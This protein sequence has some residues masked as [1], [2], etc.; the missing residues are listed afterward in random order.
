M[1]TRYQPNH[2]TAGQRTIAGDYASYLQLSRANAFYS[3]QREGWIAVNSDQERKARE[4]GA[5]T[6]SQVLDHV[7]FSVD[8]LVVIADQLIRYPRKQFEGRSEPYCTKQDLQRVIDRHPRK[9]GVRKAREALDLARIGA[10]SPP[11][12]RLRLA[13]LYAGLPEPE[14]NVPIVDEDGV[15]RSQPDLSYPEYRISIE[16]D[17]DVHNAPD[18]V[19]RDIS[20]AEQIRAL[21]WTEVR[22]SNRHMALDA[23]AAV[24]KVRTELVAKGWTPTRR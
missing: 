17:G 4:A 8:E 5:T 9:R 15:E 6:M 22:I 16:Y 2:L 24:A 11:E 19:Y 10:D 13:L 18:Q 14:V 20:R 12:T 23:K 7:V 3:N 21:G 1:N